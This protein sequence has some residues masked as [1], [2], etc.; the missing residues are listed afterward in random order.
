MT[1]PQ[2]SAG[3]FLVNCQDGPG[4]PERATIAFILAVTAS[5]TAETAMFVTSD[6][7]A[8]CVKGGAD[9]VAAEGYEPLRDLM[10]TYLANGGQIWLCPA[11]AKA[12]GLT[13]GDLVEG[14]EIAGAPRTMAFLAGGAKLLA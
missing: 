6:A 5:K 2:V 11:C 12:K 4:H 10:A 1:I 13:Q 14:V 8:L 3:K 7:A 9:V